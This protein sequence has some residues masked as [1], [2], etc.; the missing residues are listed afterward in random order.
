[1]FEDATASIISA[2]LAS[3]SMYR[4]STKVPAFTIPV[5]SKA[6]WQS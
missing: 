1:M 5:S 3:N 6:P 4:F 2:R